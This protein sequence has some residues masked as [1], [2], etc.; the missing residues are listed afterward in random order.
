[1][2]NG[3]GINFLRFVREEDAFSWSQVFARLPFDEEEIRQ[4]GA[5]FGVVRSEQI[6]NWADREIEVTNWVEEYFNGEE[7]GGNL[8]GFFA[9]F[10][11]KYPEINCVWLWVVLEKIGE[12]G[13]RKLKAVGKGEGFLEIERE[14]V[15]IDLSENLKT[16]KIVLGELKTGDK[17]KMWIGKIE[18]DFEKAE[19]EEIGSY[20]AFKIEV[21]D[22]EVGETEKKEESEVEGVE[23]PSATPG[24]NDFGG[25][26]RVFEKEDLAS[27]KY[28]GPV[29]LAL[30]LKNWWGKKRKASVVVE[31]GGGKQK[32]WSLALG[33]VFLGLLITSIV[34]GTLRKNKIERENEWLG[35]SEPI[36]KSLNEALGLTKLN[37]TGSKK[38]VEDAKNTFNLKKGEFS[39]E[40]YKERIE[41]LEKKIGE[42]WTSVSGEKNGEITEVVNLEL[43]RAGVNANRMSFVD[44]GKLVVTSSVSGLVMSVDARQKEVKVVAGKGAGLGWLDSA[45]DGK[46]FF[47]LGKGSLFVAGNETNTL[48]F[49]T[50]VTDPLSLAS[51]GASVYVLE[52]GNKEVFKFLVSESG[53][54]ERT[55]WLKEGQVIAGVPL[56]MDIDVDIWVL[57]EKGQLERFRRGVR[58]AFS[59]RGLQ[60]DMEFEK[61]S[62]EKEGNRIALLSTKSGTVVF[63]SKEDGSCSQQVKT[64]ELKG[65]KDIVFDGE[66]RL[67]VLFAGTIGVLN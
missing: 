33:V 42:T 60:A 17:I 39:E 40:E 9:N 61:V 21:S 54:G 23:I 1:M 31:T 58:E 27:D 47:V 57:E 36:E 3:F 12:Q 45:S 32:K 51:F 52:K 53:F 49:D 34:L 7:K 66:N 65:A 6:E 25:E 44:G 63:C 29:S 43:I 41:S 19:T 24:S 38:L 26:V 5:L 55:R 14:G 15:K 16:G 67:L 20:A 46:K 35:F 13:V 8:A 28:V 59:L 50:A 62:V 64:E 48:V 11:E 2:N 56:D 22:W 4:K 10:G 18:G 37:P 30:R